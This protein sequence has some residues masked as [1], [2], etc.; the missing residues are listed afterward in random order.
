VSCIPVVTIA[1]TSATVTR[2]I[3]TPCLRNQRH[4][5]KASANGSTR[6]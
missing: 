5:Q 6:K 4:V 2:L 3:A 1:L